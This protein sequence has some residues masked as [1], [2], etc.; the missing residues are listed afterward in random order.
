M[1]KLRNWAGA[2]FAFLIHLS[3]R[4]VR[5]KGISPKREGRFRIR[6]TDA[7]YS[8]TVVRFY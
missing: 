2:F 4:I 3:Y 1:K 5:N 7:A 8:E 6:R